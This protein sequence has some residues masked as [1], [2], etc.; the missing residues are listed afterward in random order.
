ML[1]DVRKDTPESSHGIEHASLL[2]STSPSLNQSSPNPLSPSLPKPSPSPSH[3]STSPSQSSP[4][5]LLSPRSSNVQPSPVPSPLPTFL[6]SEFGA[7]AIRIKTEKDMSPQGACSKVKCV[8]SEIS[9]FCTVCIKKGNRTSV[10]LHVKYSA[11]EH[12]FH[13]RKDQAFCY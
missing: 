10:L 9:K 1:R 7:A 11:C 4:R 12:F 5:P 6:D 8:S 13:I 2:P 3:S